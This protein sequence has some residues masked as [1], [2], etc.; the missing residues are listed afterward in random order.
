MFSTMIE[1]KIMIKL[2]DVKDNY[3]RKIPKCNW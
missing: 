1:I 3:L 2:N